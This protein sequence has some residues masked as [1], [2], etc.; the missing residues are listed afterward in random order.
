MKNAKYYLIMMLLLSLSSFSVNTVDSQEETSPSPSHGTWQ[1]KRFVVPVDDD[2]VQRAEVVGGEF[3]YDP[4]VIVVKVNKPVELK[5]RKIAGVIPHNL[6]AR[7]PEAGIDFNADLKNEPL[8]IRFTP[9]RTGTYPIY[10]DKGFLWF[11]THRDKGME[12]MIEVV[13]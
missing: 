10:C 2:G 9:T 12:G 7:A 8:T 11:K 5:V 1:E 13:K 4:N 3:F 6:I